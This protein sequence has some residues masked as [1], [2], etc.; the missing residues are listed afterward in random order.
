MGETGYIFR[1]VPDGVDFV[2]ELQTQVPN[3]F[4]L[5]QNYPNPSNPGSSI[6]YAIISRQFVTIK[7]YDAFGNE[8]TTLVNEEKP[9]G[10]DN[11][12]FRMQNLE[13]SSGIYFY[14][15]KAGDFFDTKKMLLI[16]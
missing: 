4:I 10:S 5:E 2:N 7:V 9:A 3:K 1:Y 11:V 6:Q 16:K 13:L 8:I 14:Q 15:L 12:E